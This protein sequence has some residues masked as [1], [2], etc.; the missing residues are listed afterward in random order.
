MKISKCQRLSTHWRVE[1]GM[2]NDI[3][4][5]ETVSNLALFLILLALLTF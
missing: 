2:K 1:S 3:Y 5:T 4:C